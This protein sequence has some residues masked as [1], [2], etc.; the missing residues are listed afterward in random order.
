MIILCTNFTGKRSMKIS[1]AIFSV[2][3]MCFSSSV[4]AV[5]DLMSSPSLEEGAQVYKDR[6]VLCHS[7]NGKGDGLLPVSI[8]NLK[9]PNLLDRKYSEDINSLRYIIIWGGMQNKMSI[10]SPPWGNELT[11]REIESLILFINYLRE[12]NEQAV[13]LLKNSIVANEVDITAGR[14]IFNKRCAICHS[15]TGD[16]RGRIAKVINKPAPSD[17]RHSILSDASLKEIISNGGAS[18]SR[19]PGM[20]P[21]KSEL[22]PAELD[23]VVSY[24]K[25][26]RK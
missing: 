20:P 12:Q 15:K 25:S 23:S 21:W 6:C 7:Q 22:S 16:G 2:F 18:V 1:Y 4:F 24:I 13:K 19:S 10:F 17:L 14:L 9:K 5:F 11:W 8:L 26:L 3:F